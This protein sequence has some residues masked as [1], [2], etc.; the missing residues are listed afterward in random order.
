MDKRLEERFADA[1]R[2]YAE[3]GVDVDK[4]IKTL[5]ETEVSLQCWAGDDIKGFEDLGPIATQNVITGSYPYTARNGDELRRDI[6]EAFK[7]S[8]LKK[9]VALH[10]MYAERKNPRN[11]LNIEDFR[12]WV[13]WAKKEKIALDFNTSFFAHPMMK[14]GMSVASFD[15]EIRDYWIK[16][17]I[18][19]RKISAAIGKELGSM[20]WNNFWFPDGTKDEP[21][22][23]VR[24]RELLKDSL[25]KIFETPYSEEER[26]YAKDALEGKWFGIGTES[27]VVGSHEF[28]L[29]YAAKNDLAIT[30]DMGHFR[31]SEDVSDKLSAVYPFVDGVMLHV[32]RGVH[33]DSDHVVIEN[34]ELD[35]MMKELKRGDYLGKVG[36]GL[37]YFDA[38][39]SRVASW[40]IG[41]RAVARSLLKALLEPTDLLNERELKGDLTSRLLLLEELKALPFETVYEYALE[42]KGIPSG[43]K[44]EEALKRYEKEYQ[45]TRK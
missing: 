8:P 4:A 14:D 30:L 31:P 41:L 19:S 7:Y 21:I 16:C 12:L 26:K 23:K 43:L 29:G 39:I 22:N 10:S 27:F 18:D 3:Y 6:E 32:S 20:V 11:D 1:K 36:I 40:A 25:D 34:D 44:L 9:R 42:L 17:G 13:D 38:T 28:Y 45:S 33:W 15:K 37:D 2:R 5:F 35:H 24:Y